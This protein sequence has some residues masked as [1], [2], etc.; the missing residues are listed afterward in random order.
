MPC[1]FHGG[2]TGIV[3]VGAVL[4]GI[5]AGLGGPANAFGP[6]SVGGDLAAQ[7]VGVGDDG[8]HFFQGVLRVLGIVSKGQHAAG[9]ADLDHVSAVLNIFA[10][11]V[12]HGSNAIGNA[13]VGL[14]IF[15]GQQVVVA[16][17]AGDAESRAAG[18]NPG[19]GDVSSL[20]R[21]AEGDVAESGGADVAY[22][23]ESRLQGKAGIA[24]SDQGLARNGDRQ[25]FVAEVRVHR[26]VRVRVDESGQ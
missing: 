9:G 2:D 25:R 1:F 23:R 6:V 4:D 17:S 19:T 20:D 8:L 22:R 18:Q 3:D 7:A 14:V 5:D 11:F 16:V 10:D 15:E 21:V 26:Q 13:V 24:S 12:L